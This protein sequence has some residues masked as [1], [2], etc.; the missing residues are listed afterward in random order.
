MLRVALNEIY[1][2]YAT[3]QGPVGYARVEYRL[4]KSG[5]PGLDVWIRNTA[6]NQIETAISTE[7]AT[8]L[9]VII[10]YEDRGSYWKIEVRQWVF[11][12]SWGTQVVETAVIVG[13]MFKILYLIAAAWVLWMIA[14][15]V[16]ETSALVWGPDGGGNGA[17]GIPWLPL[18]IMVFAGAVFI[19]SVT[20][21]GTRNKG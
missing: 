12:A 10:F 2:E 8:P 20:K 5:I 18:S 16:K 7:G 6:I 4:S 19:T 3:Y 11:D 13:M 9:Q 1:P 17:P 21:F 14:Q 15:L